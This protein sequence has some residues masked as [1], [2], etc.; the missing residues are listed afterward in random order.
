[1]KILTWSV[2]HNCQ[3]SRIIWAMA[4]SMSSVISR[5]RF[6]NPTAPTTCIGFKPFQGIWH[7]ANSHSITPKLYISHLQASKPTVLA[8][9][10]FPVMQL[11]AM[12][13]AGMFIQVGILTSHLLAHFSELQ[14]PSIQAA[15]KRQT[16]CLLFGWKQS[17][18]GITRVYH[19]ICFKE[20]EPFQQ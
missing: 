1:M 3:Q 15:L 2:T 17:E 13:H 4:G 12:E 20:V 5:C 11:L 18:N 16:S 9:E 8:L 10:N 19:A 6:W 7:V 14:V